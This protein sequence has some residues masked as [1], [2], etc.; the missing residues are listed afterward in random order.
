[1]LSTWIKSG[2]L[3]GWI[4]DAGRERRIPLV[5]ILVFSMQLL[6]LSNIM[7]AGLQQR[8]IPRVFQEDK[9]QYASAYQDLYSYDQAQGQC[10]REI[11]KAINTGRYGS[12]GITKVIVYLKWI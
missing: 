1:M 3:S 7:V 5:L 9:A 8:N 12:W 2:S 6:E 4:G 11:H 10:G